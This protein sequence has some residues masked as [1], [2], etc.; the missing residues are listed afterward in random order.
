M[1]GD[2]AQEDRPGYERNLDAGPVS[3]DGEQLRSALAG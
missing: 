3:A 2:T 1:S